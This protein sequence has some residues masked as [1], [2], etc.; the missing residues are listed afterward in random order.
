MSEKYQSILTD[1]KSGKPKAVYPPL[2]STTKGQK[3][4]ERPPDTKYDDWV[5][6]YETDPIFGPGID[7]IVDYICG[8][9]ITVKLHSVS[10]NGDEVPVWEAP[11]FM[12][13]VRLSRRHRVN[14]LFVK[15]A[16]LNGTAYIE[17]VRTKANSIDAP[18]HK[19]KNIPP[20]KMRVYRDKYMNVLSYKQEIGGSEEPEFRPENV[21]EYKFHEVTGKGYGCSVARRVIEASNIL[22]NIGL[23]L[24][25][26][27]GTKAF[28]PLLWLLGV[29][30]NGKPWD[31]DDVI[32]FMAERESV[33]P[34]DQVG[35]SGDVDAKAI[36]VADAALDVSSP[37]NF[38]ASEIVNG[39]QLP[40]ALST[41][42]EVSNQF[43]TETQMTAFDIFVTSVRNDLAELHEVELFDKILLSH[44]YD[45]LYSEVVFEQ[46]NWEKE[47]VDVNN[48]IQLLNAKLYSVEYALHKLGDPVDEAQRGT[49]INNA[50]LQDPSGTG[51][52]TGENKNLDQLDTSKSDN[53]TDDVDDDGRDGSRRVNT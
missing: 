40:S 34:G 22:R 18:I 47:R 37:M 16:L 49:I 14:K 13:A 32:A 29:G 10:K 48:I 53:T 52:G 26:F 5:E 35:V 30:P 25:E 42:I 38:F 2:A 28:P 46:H 23:D 24:A 27:I 3:E 6:L 45:D 19:F 20:A 7:H 1:D 21:V 50:P 43:V 41:V 44:G 8:A 51:S 17:L 36:G 15:D 31:R 33:H 11:Q 4:Y 12:N 39:M 9:G